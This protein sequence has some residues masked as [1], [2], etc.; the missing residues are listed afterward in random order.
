MD[1]GIATFVVQND[2]GGTG[3]ASEFDTA[4]ICDLS[5]SN[6]VVGTAFWTPN[7]AAVRT[8][9]DFSMPIIAGK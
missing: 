2:I 9:V 3:G 7:N 6:N 8:H 5:N 4:L 1:S